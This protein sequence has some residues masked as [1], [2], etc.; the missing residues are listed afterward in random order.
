MNGRWRSLGQ[1]AR[2][3]L[4]LALVLGATVACAQD[5]HPLR[6]ADLSS[7]RAAI[8][9]F[10]ES[11]DALREFA[12]RQYLPSPSRARYEQV[13][14]LA[15]KTLLS[16]DLSEIPPAARD[17][18]GY[19][20]ANALY[21]VLSR[22]A[23]PPLEQIPDAAQMAK[24]A[25]LAPA[26]A[27]P[28]GKPDDTR[29]A[30]AQRWV[31]PDTRIALVRA[32]SGP[33]SDEFLFSVDTVARAGEFYERVRGLR[34]QRQTALK[35][36]PDILL[37]AGGWMIPYAWIQALPAPMRAPILGQSAWKWVGLF[38]VPVALAALLWIVHRL[39]RLPENRSPLARE[40]ARLAVPAAFWLSMPAVEH[41]ALV[42][43]L[44]VGSVGS[45]VELATTALT[46]V[47]AAWTAW[48]VASVIAEVIIV[49]SPAAVDTRGHPVVRSV[50]RLLGVVAAAV[51][52]VM[53][54]DRIG[55]PLY[56]VVAG[57]GVGGLAVALAAQPTIENLIGGVS[58]VADRA[59]RVGEYCR[60][61][62]DHGTVERVGLRSTL[63]RGLDRTLTNI[64]NA[65]L[66][67]L[68]I[69]ALTRR[70][71]M[72]IR[73]V[74]GLRYETTPEQLR[75][76]LVELGRLLAAHARVETESAR[77]RLVEFSESALNVEVFAYVSSTDWGE[78]L[79]IQ[80]EILLRVLEIIDRGGTALAFPSQTLYLAR[81]TG[82][83]A[84]R[85]ET[86]KTNLGQW[87]D[88]GSA[89][90]ERSPATS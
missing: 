62:D 84:A 76:V 34:Y 54:A 83:D 10:L 31:I 66:A 19:A 57:L 73:T 22:I 60:Y 8:R 51:L 32:A 4:S 48:R 3:A 55:M 77:A 5:P 74:I 75:Y 12:A 79:G 61:G 64:P 41:V 40:L 52:F 29:N 16:L 24:L 72:L 58:L 7:P 17:E 43:L 71:Q 28:A 46:F 20:A 67:K 27:R 6:P 2:A 68:P 87:L 56:G 23:L 38:L 25:P 35:D 69:V 45:A 14:A 82:I 44:L 78:F 26:E 86:V 18:R 80:E 42:Q 89:L 9:T 30:V 47:A 53:G 36:L 70:D 88:E 65:V 11:G 37:S 85:T 39:T 50:A 1:V 13:Q 63:F 21:E 15:D 49:S 33:H 90:P 59:I 81:D